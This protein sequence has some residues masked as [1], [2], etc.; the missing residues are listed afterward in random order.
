MMKSQPIRIAVFLIIGSIS[1]TSAVADE[2]QV[3]PQELMQRFA[4][5]SATAKWVGGSRRRPDFIKPLEDR[6][7]RSR[8]LTL[9]GLVKQ[10]EA[11]IPVL[12]KILEK[13][14]EPQRILAA[15]TLGYLGSEVP[16]DP[17]LDIARNDDTAA[18]RLYAVDSLGMSGEKAATVPWPELLE[19]ESNRDVKKH[20]QYAIE[21]KNAAIDPSA[22]E[23]LHSWDPAR[24]DS[25]IVGKPAP[26]FELT[27]A[28]GKS[29]RLSQFRDK[30]AVVLVFIYGDT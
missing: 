27:S 12:L 19:A 8:M 2:P 6:G 9:Q 15:Q 30:Q 25:A 24:I 4:E 26:D 28:N 18:V 29:F 14:S 16:V 11:A 17:L 13:G 7:W 3:A 1:A 20:I 23:Q 22:I 10:P 5:T 21:R